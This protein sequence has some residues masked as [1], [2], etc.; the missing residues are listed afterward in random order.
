MY[1]RKASRTYKDKTYFNYLLVESVVTPKGPRQKVIC[2]LGDLSPR[3]K[4]EWLK[5][6]RKLETALTGQ[7]E[8]FD[9]AGPDPEL[10]RLVAKARAGTRR[11]A[12]HEQ[13]LAAS[14]EP[15][16]EK[17]TVCTDRVRTEES[18]EAGTVHVGYQFWQR[19]GLEEILAQAGLSERARRITCVMTLNRLIHPSSELAMPDW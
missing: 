15:G 19:L 12:P 8:L 7:Q 9:D 11:R 6:A 2:S 3:P 16:E 1:I 4:E 10:K 14:A 5:L 18:R 13:A 17:I